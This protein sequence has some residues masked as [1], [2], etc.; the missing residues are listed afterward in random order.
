[1]SKKA[2][3]KIHG[4]NACLAVFKRRPEGLVRVY[5]TEARMKTLSDVVRF[6]V[7]NRLAYHVSGPAELEK[8]SGAV[9]H[10]GVCFVIKLPAFLDA[11]DLTRLASAPGQWLALE[12]VGNPHNLGAIMRTAAHFGAK[13]VFLVAPQGSW[14]TGAFYRTAE[15]GAEVVPVIPVENLSELVALTGEL[16]LTLYATSGNQGASLYQGKLTEK[17]VF[18]MGAEGPGLSTE[19]LRSASKT[20][21]VPGTELVESLNVSSATALFMGEWYR[22][23]GP[24]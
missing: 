18:F 7:K 19:A 11:K 13:G 24:R 23:H 10:E 1:M 14:E 4:F 12:D 8:V 17:A 6:C 20:L 5:L 15:G 22:Q 2:E 3:L 9:H 16:G 21:R